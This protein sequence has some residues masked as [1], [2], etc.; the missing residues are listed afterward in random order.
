[1]SKNDLKVI[2]KKES[3]DIPKKIQ[4]LLTK[5]NIL[6]QLPWDFFNYQG[7]LFFRYLMSIL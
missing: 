7:D 1:M 3:L 6:L 2:F 5:L 4:N